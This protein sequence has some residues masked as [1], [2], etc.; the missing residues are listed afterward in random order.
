ME[1]FFFNEEILLLYCQNQLKKHFSV[2]SYFTNRTIW[3]SGSKTRPVSSRLSED[4]HHQEGHIW[5]STKDQRF[6]FVTSPTC[7][8]ERSWDSQQ[9]WM[10]SSNG[11]GV[12]KALFPDSNQLLTGMRAAMSCTWPGQERDRAGWCDLLAQYGFHRHQVEHL[13]SVSICCSL[14]WFQCWGQSILQIRRAQWQKQIAHHLGMHSYMAQ[15]VFLKYS[16]IAHYP[17]WEESE[18]RI[19]PNLSLPVDLEKL[20]GWIIIPHLEKNWKKD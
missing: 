17:P 12:Q 10:L 14:C 13:C 20:R 18:T 11:T 19:T 2:F 16:V 6:V 8:R 7:Q 1:F 9:C 3:I 15:T 4:A 5:E